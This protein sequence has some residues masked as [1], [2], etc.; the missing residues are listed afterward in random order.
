MVNKAD[1]H[2]KVVREVEGPRL[3]TL[4]YAHRIAPYL[5]MLLGVLFLYR[6]LAAGWVLAGGDLQTYFFPYWTAVARAV[7]AG[8]LPLWNPYLFAGAPLLA[9]SQA[10]VFYPLNWPLWLLAGPS[11]AGMTRALHWSVLLHLGLAAVNVAILARRLGLRPWSAALSGL[12][13]AGSGYLGVHVE[14]LNQ[15]QGMAWLP[16]MFLPVD[17][18]RQTVDR[19]GSAGVGACGRVGERGGLPSPVSVG[20]LALIA[21]AGHT[22]MA[23]IAVVGLVVWVVGGELPVAGCRLKVGTRLPSTVYRL[24]SRFLP[25]VLAGLIAAAQ[26]V[27]TIELA[28]FSPRSGGLP[29]RE[30]VSFSVRPWELPRALLPPYL[31]PPLL[32]EAVAY[33]GLAGMALV[34]WGGWR[35]LRQRDRYGLALVLLGGV[36]V[37][38]AVGG[39]N[40]LYLAA[41][42]LGAPGF[43]H[44]RAP[45]RFLALYVLAAALLAGMGLESL[46]ATEVQRTQRKLDKNFCALRVFVVKFAPL[47]LVGVAFVELAW[48]AEHMPHADATA[49][50]AYTDLRPATA[51]LVAA[52]RLDADADQ[53][54][55]RFLSLSPTLFEAGDETE[56]EAVYGAALSPDALWAY[57][58]AV[59]QREVLA[60]NLLLA[61]EVPAVDGYDGGLLPLRHYVAFSRLFLPE[62]TLDGRLRENLTTIPEGRWLSLLGVRF[63]MTDKTGDAW[64]DGVFYDRQFQPHLEAGEALTLAWLPVDFEADTLG[65]LYSGAGE[66][67]VTTASGESITLPL[68]FRDPDQGAYRLPL[69][70]VTPAASLTVRAAAGGLTLL[71]ASLIDGRTGAFYPLAL[72]DYFRLVH[73]GDVK[74]YENTRVL[75]R[76][77]LV[78]EARC[79]ATDDDALALMRDPAFDPALQAV[80]NCESLVVDVPDTAALAAA[81]SVTVVRYTAEEIV[82][83]LTITA[84]ALLVLADAWY[85]AW[86]VQVQSLAPDGVVAT[87]RENVLRT[88]VLFRGVPVE[89]GV[90]R[91][92][93]AYRVTPVFAGIGLSILGVIG[94][95]CYNCYK[96]QLCYCSKKDIIKS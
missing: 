2:A 79:V 23:F 45:A 16:L 35:A 60:P 82:L 22:Q 90:W 63:L 50:R 76:A 4:A 52:A 25:F 47:A 68:P 24:L 26:L 51:H 6:R 21:L 66:V 81:E 30:A 88:D 12:L 74:I 54:P 65:W 29:W 89:P 15:L 84:P 87:R 53:P 92:A 5:L 44:F 78:H 33:I 3:S 42:R 95:V 94:L 86:K 17:G 8:R 9:N 48:S 28:R 20:A 7:Q 61:F 14:H 75:P 37:F 32:P 10:G 38:L 36:G 58:V 1:A 69:G 59:K 72:S 43:A 55:G 83:D 46:L 11:L 41:A 73:S 91:V 39:Y 27:P 40:P 56:I 62:G 64:A 80:V 70:V 49:P 96:L 67:V 31:W 19:G 93:F 71:G 77:F 13:Y 18:R 34:A 85:P 57:E